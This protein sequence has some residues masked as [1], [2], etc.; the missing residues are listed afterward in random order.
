MLSETLKI[1]ST[2]TLIIDDQALVCA[3]G[4]PVGLSSFGDLADRFVQSVFKSQK[5]FSRIDIVFDRQ[6]RLALGVRERKVQTQF[7]NWW[8][9]EKFPYH[10]I[11]LI[12]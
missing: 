12:F 3:I 1:E 7:A 11:G 5:D 4:K 8:T 10:T 2:A 9:A 6:S